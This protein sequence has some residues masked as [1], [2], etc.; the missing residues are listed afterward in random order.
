[1]ATGTNGIA[2]RANA[3]SLKPGSYS[4]DLS[5]CITYASAKSAGFMVKDDL[6]DPR[7]ANTNRLVR[8]S[9]LVVPVV[10]SYLTFTFIIDISSDANLYNKGPITL[11]TSGTLD[12]GPRPIS[13]AR[14]VEATE[15]GQDASGIPLEYSNTQ[16]E[17]CDETGMTLSTVDEVLQVAQEFEERDKILG[18]VRPP[19]R[20]VLGMTLTKG[21]SS[22]NLLDASTYG[23]VAVSSSKTVTFTIYSKEYASSDDGTYKLSFSGGSLMNAD[24]IYPSG[25]LRSSSLTSSLTYQT[26]TVSGDGKYTF[27]AYWKKNE[28]VDPSI[29]PSL[30]STTYTFRLRFALNSVKAYQ[31]RVNF[32]CTLYSSTGKA[33]GTCSINNQAYR[34]DEIPTDPITGINSPSYYYIDLWTGDTLPKYVK[35]STNTFATRPNTGNWVETAC[36][37]QNTL[38]PSGSPTISG[39]GTAYLTLN[40]RG[41]IYTVDYI[42]GRI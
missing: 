31:I 21:D 7:Y 19:V 14:E 40:P 33:L 13:Y 23:P 22:T 8:Y 9:D 39:S 32:S 4:S 3:N 42:V 36:A 25:S 30:P 24:G 29:D 27:D 2:T 10:I 26:L 18:V 17:E 5:R 11:K 15:V 1:M 16:V 28:V 41:T 12:V 35:V 37:I 20:P 34:F 6:H 38:K